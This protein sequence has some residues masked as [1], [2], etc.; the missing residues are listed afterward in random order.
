MFQFNYVVMLKPNPEPPHRTVLQHRDAV[1]LKG[2]GRGDR[3]RLTLTPLV[4][5]NYPAALQTTPALINSQAFPGYKN[6]TEE[7]SVG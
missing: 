3:S 5:P 7:D 2:G 6:G 1:P 4:F